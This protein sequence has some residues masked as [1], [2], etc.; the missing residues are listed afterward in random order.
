MMILTLKSRSLTSSANLRIENCLIVS[1]CS[2]Y[3]RNF[4]SGESSSLGAILQ[5]CKL[6]MDENTNRAD[7]PLQRELDFIDELKRVRSHLRQVLN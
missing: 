4:R 6:L 5:S 2:Y 3:A 1:E 7:L